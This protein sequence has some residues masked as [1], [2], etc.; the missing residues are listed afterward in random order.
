M[1]FITIGLTKYTKNMRK[2]KDDE[3][4]NIINFGALNYNAKQI[5]LILGDKESSILDLLSDENSEFSKLYN[6]GK[7]TAEYL[8]DWKLCE[9]AKAGDLAALKKFEAR[10]RLKNGSTTKTN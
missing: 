5:S 4:E 7:A 3:K 2:F 10:K 8:I 6:K 1:I 9:M